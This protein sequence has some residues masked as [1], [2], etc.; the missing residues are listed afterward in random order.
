LTTAELASPEKEIVWTPELI[1]QLRGKRTQ[2]EFGKLLG[3]PKNT[4]WRWEAGRATP[5]AEHYRSLS[6]FAA[7]EHFLTG[8]RLVGSGRILKDLEKGSK[9]ISSEL[10]KSVNRSARRL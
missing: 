7:G 3:V 1:K 9:G 8:W 6:R 2:A 5:D 10:L 4:V